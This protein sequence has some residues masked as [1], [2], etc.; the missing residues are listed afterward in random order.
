MYGDE[1]EE[2]VRIMRI[3]CGYW[4]DLTGWQTRAAFHEAGVRFL[5]DVRRELDEEEREALIVG[6]RCRCPLITPPGVTS[7][8]S[9]AGLDTA[10]DGARRGA[11]AGAGAC[12]CSCL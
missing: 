2:Q 6:G 4:Q 12:R 5:I 1:Y 10:R 8:L 7:N 9:E 3:R 11:G